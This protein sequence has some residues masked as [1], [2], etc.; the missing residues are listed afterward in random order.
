MPAFKEQGPQPRAGGRA[1]GR[2]RGAGR[3]LLGGRAGQV[4]HGQ[5]VLREQVTHLGGQ[6]EEVERLRRARRRAPAAQVQH[7]QV[8]PG[9]HMPLVGRLRAQGTPVH[10]FMEALKK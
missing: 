3:A 8:E 4:H 7:A 1:R 10:A 5:V 2:A 6:A 9:L